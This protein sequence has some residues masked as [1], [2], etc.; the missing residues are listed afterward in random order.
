MRPVRLHGSDGLYQTAKQSH[1]QNDTAGFV[2]LAVYFAGVGSF[3]A[4]QPPPRASIS[5]T[6][7]VRR[8]VSS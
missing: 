6:L 5:K 7:D 2:E 4:S 1:G 3:E 8:R